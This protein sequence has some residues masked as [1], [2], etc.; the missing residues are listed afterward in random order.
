MKYRKLAIDLRFRSNYYD[1]K[2]IYSKPIDLSKIDGF[3]IYNPETNSM[4]Y[5]SSVAMQNKAKSITL[6]IRSSGNNQKHGVWLA[7][8]FRNPYDMMPMLSDKVINLTRQ[9]HSVED[10]SAISLV[11][12]DL[13][14]QGVQSLL[15]QSA[16][17]PSSLLGI[18]KDMKTLMRY[19]VGI[20]ELETNPYVDIYEICFSQTG[21]I[22]Y[23]PAN[24]VTKEVKKLIFSEEWG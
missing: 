24:I 3:A 15:P 16:Y 13:M 14:K 9:H 1:S 17:L 21:V 6:R 2:K 19:R 20:D 11:I 23:I 7:N 12:A 18:C 4:Y 5:L 22:R 8:D 10:E